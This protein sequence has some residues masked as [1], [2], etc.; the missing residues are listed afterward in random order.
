M[1]AGLF[2]ID[3]LTMTYFRRSLALTQQV[4]DPSAVARHWQ[5]RAMQ[6]A[7]C[8]EWID[9]EIE[10]ATRFFERTGDRHEYEVSVTVQALIATY[11]GEYSH[12]LELYGHLVDS[13]RGR[14]IQH[15]V[16]GTYKLGEQLLLQDGRHDDALPSQLES[17]ELLAIEPEEPTEAAINWLVGAI[18]YRQGDKVAASDT[19]HQAFERVKKSPPNTH[20][21]LMAYTLGIWTL[22]DLQ[23]EDPTPQAR[24]RVRFAL[25]QMGIFAFLFPFAKG[26]LSMLK[27]R[28]ALASGKAGK[29]RTLLAKA[30]AH[31]EK[32]GMKLDVALAKL[33]QGEAEADAELDALGA[34]WFIAWGRARRG[35]S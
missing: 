22:L 32:T 23:D 29:A 4:G 5:L 8:G 3:R 13:A 7:G 21:M 15:T 17:L 20:G 30:V 9:D 16:W 24:K 12:S 31:G 6:R 35:S 2:Q 34:S 10:Q 1:L 19:I 26:R 14:S 28:N 25:G 27:A 11:R 33:V 18:R